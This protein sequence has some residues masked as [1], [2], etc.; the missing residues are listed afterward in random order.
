MEGV[1]AS[2]AVTGVGVVRGVNSF[3]VAAD[4]VVLGTSSTIAVG[5]ETGSATSPSNGRGLNRRRA[6]K[7][8]ET[9]SDAELKCC[10]SH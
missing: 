7:I 5:F 4:V 6:A 1:D 10:S 3:G 2:E 9:T 8:R